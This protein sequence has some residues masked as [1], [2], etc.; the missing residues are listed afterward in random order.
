MSES[1]PRF[2]ARTERNLST[3]EPAL[4]ALA[5]KF[6]ALAQKALPEGVTVKVISGT[7]S[8]EEQDALYAQGR[9][10]P[11][12]IVTNARAGYSNHNFG[13]SLDVGLFRGADY[14]EE[15]PWYAKLGP[16]GESVG[17]AW[18]GRWK[19]LVD[20]PHY[21]LKHGLTLAELRRRKAARIP[22]LKGTPYEQPPVTAPWPTHWTVNV[23]GAVRAVDG[24]ST[25]EV[26]FVAEALGASVAVSGKV[27][28]ITP[29]G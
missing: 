12:P 13:L 19:G 24:N 9:T 1:A 2:D 16:L 10:R 25:D 14:L 28:T 22:L 3:L 7:R 4:Q 23:N 21:E 15:S 17:L 29:K 20:T 11:G 18:G 6:L 27:I 8:Y 26:R 5:R